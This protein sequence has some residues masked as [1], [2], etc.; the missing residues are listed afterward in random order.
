MMNKTTEELASDVGEHRARFISA[1]LRE[2][3]R[4]KILGQ[5]ITAADLGFKFKTRKKFSRAAKFISLDGLKTWSGVGR[6][7]LWFVADLSK[8]MEGRS[9]SLETATN[10]MRIGNKQ[11]AD[12][13]KQTEPVNS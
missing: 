7:P 2:I 6:T 3:E 4:F 13:T 9:L 10:L 12:H 5:V 8:L 1:T 11:H